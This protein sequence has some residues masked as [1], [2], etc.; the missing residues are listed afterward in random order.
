MGTETKF[1]WTKSRLIDLIEFSRHAPPSWG[2]TQVYEEFIDIATNP[3]RTFVEWYRKRG[4]E[5]LNNLT[6]LVSDIEAAFNLSREKILN[7][8]LTVKEY[9]FYD[10]KDFL[11]YREQMIKFANQ[12]K[13]MTQSPENRTQ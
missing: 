3:D 9:R 4:Q 1:E 10:F 2:I 13:Q 6:Y 12:P 11:R 7:Q 8:N 5:S